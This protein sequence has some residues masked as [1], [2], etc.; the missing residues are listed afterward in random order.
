MKKLFLIVPLI[1]ILFFNLNAHPWKP[2]H[3]VIIDTDGGIDDFRAISL[4]M[5]SPDVRVLGITIS[6]GV[7]SAND[8]Y[9]KV[10][11]LLLKNYHEG[12]PVGINESSEIVA[13]NYTTAREFPWGDSIVN[14]A[15]AHKAMDVLRNLY[16]HSSDS[17][18]FICLGSLNIIGKAS[19]E[20][21]EFLSKTS[22]IVWSS[23]PLEDG[24]NFNFN[25]DKTA[26]KKV[27]N[28]DIPIKIINGSSFSIDIFDDVFL[29]KLKTWKLPIYNDFAQSLHLGH[30]MY[31][32]ENVAL[33][34]HY[35][36]Y[37]D[38]TTND[39]LTI[40]SGKTEIARDIIQN[41][42]LKIITGETVVMNQV[43]NAFSMDS[44]DYFADV[45]TIMATTV[46]KFGKDEWVAEAMAN[47]LHRHLGVFA[48]VGA[49]MGIRAKEYF[50]AGIDEMSVVS[51]AGLIPP[52]SCMN[53]GLQVSTGA[54]LG[55]GLISVANDS[56]VRPVGDFRYMGRTIRLTLKPFY[57]KKIASEVKELNAIYGI[58]SNIY[59]EL[60]RRLAIKYWAG[61]D[62]HKIFD[63]REISS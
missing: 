63:I 5:A 14:I 57:A 3:F 37:F 40:Y 47:E 50:G 30:A 55:H 28:L 26:L 16:G 17:I 27:R 23:K 25:L 42:Y 1:L 48:I 15:N 54:T 32:D 43:L 56:L 58:N 51:Y 46:E 38:N 44:S 24:Q 10:R 22:A 41:A 11:A 31:F 45:R 6:S 8:C 29:E 36:S 52:F 9:Q 39:K 34:L 21:P 49:K 18:K 59:W 35:P 2:R 61:F 20:I 12:V 13:A 7:L 4:I 19:K 33:W 62:R 53:D 60:I